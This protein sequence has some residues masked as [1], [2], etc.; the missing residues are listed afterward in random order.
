MNPSKSLAMS[1]WVARRD[2]TLGL[3]FPLNLVYAILAQ[4]LL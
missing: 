3:A 4:I 1:A 2:L